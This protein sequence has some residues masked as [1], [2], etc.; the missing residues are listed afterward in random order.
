MKT[1]TIKSEDK[2][3]LKAFEEKLKEFGWVSDKKWNDKYRDDENFNSISCHPKEDFIYIYIH[4]NLNDYIH[5][6]LNDDRKIFHLPLQWLDAIE[7]LKNIKNS[8]FKLPTWKINDWVIT[9]CNVIGKISEINDSGGIILNI[10]EK[11]DKEKKLVSHVKNIIGY[12]P[13]DIIFNHLYSITDIKV[14][15]TVK[16]GV[17]EIQV[18][19]IKLVTSNEYMNSYQFYFKYFDENGIH[20]GIESKN[21]GLIPLNEVEKIKPFTIKTNRGEY[22]L[23][24]HN[25]THYKLKDSCIDHISLEDLESFKGVINFCRRNDM[26]IKF[27]KLIINLAKKGDE[28]VTNPVISYEKIIKLMQNLQKK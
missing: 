15:D 22:E 11:D 7:H 27:N 9:D 8:E 6:N 24:N 20:L 14:G 13:C 25:L 17:N 26:E 23:V 4:S 19:K 16:W 18:K 1:I 5:N 21:Y 28:F 12:A 10:Y 3:L 2:T